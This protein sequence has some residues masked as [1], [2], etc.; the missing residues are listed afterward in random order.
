MGRV[1]GRVEQRRDHRVEVRIKSFDACDRRVDRLERRQFTPC[2][3]FRV[4]DRVQPAQLVVHG[5]PI[6]RLA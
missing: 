6:G 1:A 5:P 2:D 3:A 4:A